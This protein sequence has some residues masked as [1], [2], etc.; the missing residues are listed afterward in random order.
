MNIIIDPFE[1]YNFIIIKKGRKGNLFPQKFYKPR[2]LWYNKSI[3]KGKVFEDDNIKVFARPTKHLGGESNSFAYIFEA[4]GKRV[5]FTGDMSRNFP[6]YTEITKGEHFD[7]VVC[8]MAHANLSDVADMLKETDTDRMYIHHYHMPRLNG[9]E[10]IFK[11]F[12]FPVT[13]AKDGEVTTL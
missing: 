8:E 1:I 13:I 10:E 2:R 7:V 6:E 3:N 12:P 5:L 9:Y 11:S 4:D